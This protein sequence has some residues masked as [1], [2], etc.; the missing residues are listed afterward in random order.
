MGFPLLPGDQDSALA[1]GQSQNFELRPVAANL[2]AGRIAGLAGIT[3]RNTAFEPS[4]NRAEVQ[5]WPTVGAAATVDGASLRRSAS[6]QDFE[7][8]RVW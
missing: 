7:G 2:A 6:L 1:S 4:C 5:K 3:S 8:S